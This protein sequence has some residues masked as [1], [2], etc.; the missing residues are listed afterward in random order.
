M[1]KD[2]KKNNRIMDELNNKCNNSEYTIF[3]FFTFVWIIQ[4]K[5]TGYICNQFHSN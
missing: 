2:V 1:L 5:K 4:T 3:N